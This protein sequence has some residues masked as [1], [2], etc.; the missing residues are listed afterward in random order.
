MGSVIEKEFSA[1]FARKCTVHRVK[2]A[3]AFFYAIAIP[4]FLIVGF[5]PAETSAEVR[6]SEIAIAEEYLDIRAIGLSTPVIKVKMER[7]TLNA[8]QYLAGSYR[9]HENK[10]LLIGHSA[11]IFENLHYL[12]VGDEIDYEDGTYI[13]SDVR[14]EAKGDIKMSQILRNENEPTVILMTCAGEPLGGMDFSHRLIITA[15]KV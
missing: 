13:V 14:T 15:K 9:S 4:A 8:P 6:S 12:E 1:R 11:T 10:T 7:N 5:Q 3:L 2:V